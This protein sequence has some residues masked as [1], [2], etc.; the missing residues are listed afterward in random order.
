VSAMITPEIQ[1]ELYKEADARFSAQTGIT[2]KLDPHS[3]LDQKWIP[4]WVHIYAQV[5]AQYDAGT[6]AWT[7][8]DA[9]V[10]GALAQAAAMGATA[11]QH[12]DAAQTATTPDAAHANT[13]AM[14]AAAAAAQVASKQAAQAQNA[15]TPP[16][17]SPNLVA[18][19]AR[20][21]FDALKT[22]G[23]AFGFSGGTPN[24]NNAIA[25]VQA[26]QAPAHAQTVAQS[27]SP[28]APSP[29]PAPPEHYGKIDAKKALIGV[30]IAGAVFGGIALATSSLGKH[31]RRRRARPRYHPR[32]ARRR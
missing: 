11:A 16:V 9:A 20:G 10:S 26:S 21:I 32:Y 14:H 25:T 13:Q 27:A 6:L 5:K 22:L 1:A 3:A 17:V 15:I 24:G 4:V 19:T 31:H 7:Y 29:A 12:F 28:S 30:G 2:H 8:K 23:S 18:Q